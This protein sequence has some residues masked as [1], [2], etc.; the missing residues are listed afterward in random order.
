MG[1][2]SPSAGGEGG[3]GG[4]FFCLS[5]GALSL[6]RREGK[7]TE[8]EGGIT[9]TFRL[10]PPSEGM[11]SGFSSAV[12]DR[13]RARVTRISAGSIVFCTD[14]FLEWLALGEVSPVDEFVLFPDRV[15]FEKKLGAIARSLALSLSSGFYS[16]CLPSVIQRCRLSWKMILERSEIVA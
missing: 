9:V 5:S 3:G 10:E 2:S 16:P 4:G 7:E 13:S 11:S 12:G 8:G 6:F 14:E 15:S 1:V